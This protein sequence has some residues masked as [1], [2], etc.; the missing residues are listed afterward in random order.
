MR[1][2]RTIALGLIA[3]LSFAGVAIAQSADPS[4]TVDI[5]VGAGSPKAGKKTKPKQ[6]KKVELE[7]ENNRAAKTTA[8]RIEIRFPKEIKINTKGFDDC[9]AS[10]LEN[11]GPSACPRGS[12]LGKGTA[13]ALVG[14]DQAP[15]KFTNEFFV[16][17]PKVLTINLKQVGG[18]VQAILLAKIKPTPKGQKLVIDIPGNLQQPAPGLYSALTSITNELEGTTGKGRKKHGIFESTGCAKGSWEFE[19]TLTYAANP[20]PPAK[21]KSSATDEVKCKK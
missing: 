21:S 13:E 3:S 10:T 9:S 6:V 15:L 11:D 19:S 2:T 5:S 14:P 7:I 16:G 18:D 1:K 8:S 17:G 12:R 4:H 20:N